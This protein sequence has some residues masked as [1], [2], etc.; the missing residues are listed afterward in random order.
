MKTMEIF[1]PA[2]CCSTGLCGVSIDPELLRVATNLN[3]LKAHNV[4]VNRY[5]LS[6]APAAFVSNS[7]VNK[8]LHE[9]GGDNLP[10]ILVD[11]EIVIMRLEEDLERAKIN[12]RW[13]V[14]NSS[15]YKAKPQGK[16]LASKATAE[17]EWINKV[18]T[19]TKGDYSL[20]SWLADD[21]KDKNLQEIIEG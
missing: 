2:M 6:S 16:L 4:I 17:V 8:E 19:H 15:M 7:A 3:N 5:N 9:H 21:I 10:L 12:V 13:W 11:G 1:E 20:I 18:G 14:I